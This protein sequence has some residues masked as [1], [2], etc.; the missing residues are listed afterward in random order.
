MFRELV[1][2]NRSCRRF[3]E[4]DPVS[5]EVLKDLVDLARIGPSA[6][7]LQP[8]RYV[9]SHKPEMNNKIFPHLSW[10]GYLTNWSGPEEGERPAAYIIILGDTSVVKS[11]NCDHGIAAQSILLGA[12]DK[13]LK[14][15]IIGS[16]NRDALHTQLKIPTT[17]KIL[18]IIALGKPRE[19]IVLEA[20]K[21]DGD[22]RYWRD[23]NDVHHVPKRSL[24]DI[25]IDI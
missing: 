9:I 18:L 22:I 25:I 2:K 23:E 11:F 14:G 8:L 7:N 10:A 12:C 17:Y 19:N 20:V 16:I 15:C 24:N 21:K 5:Y 6:S 1:L 3:Y 4:N 13:D